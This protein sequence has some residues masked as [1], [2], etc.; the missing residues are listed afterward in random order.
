[1]RTALWDEMCGSLLLPSVALSALL[2]RAVRESNNQGLGRLI[3]P[4]TLHAKTNAALL[5]N[6]ADKPGPGCELRYGTKCAALCFYRRWHYQHCCGEGR[7]SMTPSHGPQDNTKNSP[8][9]RST[10]NAHAGIARQCAS[11]TTRGPG[12]ELR[13]GTKCAALCFYRRWH[14]QHCCGEGRRW[15]LGG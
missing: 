12:C 11:P 5:H 8:A 9:E 10:V 4:S 14:Y 6:S 2:W 7:R 3:S 1:M 13:Y 15:D